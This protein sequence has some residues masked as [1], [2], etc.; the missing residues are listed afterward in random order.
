MQNNFMLH[1]FIIIINYLGMWEMWP[2]EKN[3]KNRGKIPA[4]ASTFCDT[5]PGNTIWN[6][7]LLHLI[8][9]IM[10]KFVYRPF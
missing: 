6:I 2:A 3:W 5:Q 9:L 4:Q 10:V 7:V 8:A 1:G